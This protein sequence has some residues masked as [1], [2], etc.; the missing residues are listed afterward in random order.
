M[1]L[2]H[3]ITHD[4]ESILIE[5]E[6]FAATQLPAA[7]SM[8]SLALRDHAEQIVRAIGAD[9]QTSQTRRQQQIKSQG[10]APAPLDAKET[11][12]QTHALLRAKSGFDINQLAA[13]YRALRASVLRLWMD[14]CQPA[15]SDLDDMLRFNEAVDQALAESISFFNTQVEQSRNLL[16]GMLG[17]DMRSPLQTVLTTAHY[18]AK[19][20]TDA[21]VSS[22]AKRLIASGARIKALLDDLLDYGRT[23]LG[24]G[25]P[26]VPQR[27]DLASLFA[28]ELEQLRS[29]Y[30]D[31]TVALHCSG[32][33]EGSWDGLRLQQLL[34][35][36]IVNSIK[37][38]DADSPVDVFVRGE[39][40][41][42]VVEVRNAGPAIDQD[43]L[44]AFFAPLKRGTSED[45]S[46]ASSDGL[47]LGLYIAREVARAH[48]GDLT[49]ISPGNETIF[50]CTLPRR[51]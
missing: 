25:L 35:N 34:E 50:T 29:V 42:V 32:N 51:G 43:R 4:I 20:N 24:L 7:A 18:L 39:S 47:G 31:R 44:D 26:V 16:L 27:V 33:C 49:A 1:R 8:K 12:A 45:D 9:L 3:F 21:Q 23:R 46:C 22:A 17:H 41:P 13:E 38:G 15:S 2:A 6:T 5:W 28:S 37:Y 10:L 36:L 14:R 30:P 48:G 40:D 19:I 11:A